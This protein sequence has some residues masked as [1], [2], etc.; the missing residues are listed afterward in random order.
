MLASS[1]LLNKMMVRTRVTSFFP[2]K[3]RCL[4]MSVITADNNDTMRLE[5][6][7]R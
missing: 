5:Q 6:H 4:S 1:P 3:S 7:H 2:T